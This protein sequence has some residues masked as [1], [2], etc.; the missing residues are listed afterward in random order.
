[1]RKFG[2]LG[3]KDELFTFCWSL[4]PN[5][6]L[7]SMKAVCQEGISLR[8]AQT[9][10]SSSQNTFLDITYSCGNYVKRENAEVI[11]FQ[12]QGQRSSSMW[13]QNGQTKY[14]SGDYSV[15]YLRNRGGDCGHISHLVGY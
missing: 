12:M 9:T 2:K 4:R 15:P 5:V 3:L 10:T 6:I 14:L 1:M 13:H 8:L 7:S 11:I